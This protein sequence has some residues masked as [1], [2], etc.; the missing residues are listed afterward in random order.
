MFGGVR[1]RVS[2]STPR[3]P[4]WVTGVNLGELY[5]SIDGDKGASKWVGCK[6]DDFLRR[7]FR[8]LY[9]N[10][11]KHAPAAPVYHAPH[12]KNLI[13]DPNFS[14]VSF[15]LD[16]PELGGFLDEEDSNMQTSVGEGT[17]VYAMRGL[18]VARSDYF[19]SLFSKANG[20]EESKKDEVRLHGIAPSIFLL[21]LEHLYCG[22]VV[23]EASQAVRSCE[24]CRALSWR[25][26][27]L[28]CDVR[29]T[30]CTL[31]VGSVMCVC[32]QGPLLR[33]ADLLTLFDLRET[34]ASFLAK[35]VCWLA[36]LSC[37]PLASSLIDSGATLCRSCRILL[38]PGGHPQ[39][40]EPVG[41][42]RSI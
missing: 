3:G 1:V 9:S 12:L 42:G 34:C 26:R 39:R 30:F 20:M 29:S 31:S 24:R 36:T 11:P 37:L 10:R 5:F 28:S 6:K 35:S 33:A 40:V 21:I 25:E 32:F 16:E 8:V 23:F 19:K 2:V 7:G 38:A 41:I 22:S 4:A 27:A 15:I 14:D 13:N 17:R 18:L